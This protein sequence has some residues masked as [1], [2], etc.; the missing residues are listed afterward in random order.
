MSQGKNGDWAGKKQVIWKCNLSGDPVLHATLYWPD[1]LISLAL[2]RP[3][4]AGWQACMYPISRLIIN[5][6]FFTNT[7]C[8][9]LQSTKSVVCMIIILNLCCFSLMMWPQRQL[10]SIFFTPVISYLSVNDSLS[11]N[12]YCNTWLS[13][14]HISGALDRNFDRETG[15]FLKLYMRHRA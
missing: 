9:W 12:I 7:K 14:L 6:S 15:S 10:S 5:Y 11:K 8:A 4:L 2:Y 13:S 3:L 1:I